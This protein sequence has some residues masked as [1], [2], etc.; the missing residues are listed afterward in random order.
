MANVAKHELT[1]VDDEG[2]ELK[3]QLSDIGRDTLEI[4]IALIMPSG[5]ERPK[6]LTAGEL[7]LNSCWVSGDERIKTDEQLKISA[8]LAA[9]KIYEVKKTT[10]KKL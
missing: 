3:C 6:Y 7:I 9:I 10:L 2:N 8:S 4:V 5:T 1:V